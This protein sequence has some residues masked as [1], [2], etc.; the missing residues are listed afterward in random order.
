MAVIVGV[1][2]ILNA[3]PVSQSA[4]VSLYREPVLSEHLTREV[5]AHIL[6]K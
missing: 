1:L 4:F 2:V 5:V 6:I 3:I